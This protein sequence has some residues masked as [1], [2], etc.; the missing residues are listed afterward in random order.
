ME[1]DKK[2]ADFVHEMHRKIVEAP[3]EKT[4][5][6]EKDPEAYKIMREYCERHWKG[7]GMK[8]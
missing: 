5:M 3:R 7:K 6:E 8:L 2:L 1:K 4:P